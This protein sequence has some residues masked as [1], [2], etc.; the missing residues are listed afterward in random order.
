MA[1]KGHQDY[2]ARIRYSNALPPPPFAP[3]LLE[4]VN[5]AVETGQYTSPGFGSRLFRDQP[6]NIEADAELGMRIDLVG[7]RGVFEGDESG[8]FLLPI[9]A[10]PLAHDG[11]S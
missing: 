2:V 9:H 5:N 3:K 1:H 10:Q 7:L 6:L 11:Q 8:T 4:I